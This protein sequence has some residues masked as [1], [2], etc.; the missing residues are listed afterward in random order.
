M[1]RKIALLM[2]GS[3]AVSAVPVMAVSSSASLSG[4]KSNV[5]FGSYLQSDSATSYPSAN[6]SVYVP[7]TG[8]VDA[9]TELDSVFSMKFS[10]NNTNTQVTAGDE[11]II[12]LENG[13]FPVN[14]VDVAGSFDFLTRNTDGDLISL[15]GHNLVINSAGQ[16]DSV[17]NPNETSYTYT[18]EVTPLTEDEITGGLNPNEGDHLSALTEEY[19]VA[20]N[21]ALL[22]FKYTNGEWVFDYRLSYQLITGLYSTRST[23]N[24]LLDALNEL[25]ALNGATVADFAGM[26]YKASSN[27]VA[28]IEFALIDRVATDKGILAEDIGTVKN[29]DGS[30]LV[31][32]VNVLVTKVESNAAENGNTLTPVVDPDTTTVGAEVSLRTV[33]AGVLAGNIAY[34]LTEEVDGDEVNH[35]T[36]LVPSGPRTVLNLDPD[37]RA[38]SYYD[39]ATSEIPGATVTTSDGSAT[40]VS[41]FVGV[42]GLG[43]LYEDEDN[44][45]KVTGAT[46]STY[47]AES[48]ID[49]L[50]YRATVP[51]TIEF[52][53]NE[54]AKVTI[55]TT[56]TDDNASTYAPVLRIPMGGVKASGEGAVVVTVDNLGNTA[57]ASSTVTLSNETSLGGEKT[58][59][60]LVGNPIFFEDRTQ[61][62]PLK[63]AELVPDS[64]QA[65]ATGNEIKLKLSPGFRFYNGTGDEYT[66][67][68]TSSSSVSKIEGFNLDDDNDDTLT[69]T[70]SDTDTANLSN[71]VL[72]NVWIEA[73]NED[74]ELDAYITVSS[75]QKGITTETILVAYRNNLGFSLVS[76]LDVE[77][78]DLPV[79]YSGRHYLADETSNMTYAS[80][81]TI[82]VTFSEK[83]PNT[84]VDTRNLDFNLPD[85]VKFTDL[86][87]VTSYNVMGLDEE[88]F[89]I[90]N[91]GQTLRLNRVDTAGDQYTSETELITSFVM[92]LEVS[93]APDFVGDIEVSVEGGGM[94]TDENNPSLVVA[95]AVQPFE[96]KIESTNVNLGYQDYNVSDIVITEKEAGLFL[97]GGMVYLSINAPYGIDEIGFSNAEYSVDENSGL[98][99]ADKTFKINE[100]G[101]GGSGVIEF[102]IEESSYND[103]PA[104]LTLSNVTVG[105]TR[106]VPYG[107]YN[108]K[109]AGNAVL[110]NYETYNYNYENFTVDS[111]AVV[112][113]AGDG[114]NRDD[115]DNVIYQDTKDGFYT[116]TYVN[117]VTPTATID[118]EVKVT[119]GSTTMYVGGVEYT[120]EVAPKLVNGRTLVPLRFVTL[121]LASEED[122]ANP[123]AASMIGWDK[124]TGTATIFLSDGTFV[125]FTIGSTKVNR[126]GAL[127]DMEDGS[128]AVLIDGRTYIPFRDL[129]NALGVT[130]EWDSATSTATYVPK[131]V[132]EN[133]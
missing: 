72:T 20:A 38:T 110:N 46:Y 40:L 73:E 83:V 121:A 109:L 131:A 61:I 35:G 111:K 129:G 75:V 18:I 33:S 94:G 76:T 17:L 52:L 23:D 7:S 117:L 84:L 13:S 42:S 126:N 81:D 27:P 108:L 51:Y 29:S 87:L 96:I 106:A 10:S 132:N 50:K 55:L 124:D 22:E 41:T 91:N 30:T 43:E 127:V 6:S 90:V 100:G 97:E 95:K 63:L 66:P 54:T 5:V 115:F 92:D 71:L 4:D 130:V 15:S 47:S 11:F 116:D 32:D 67:V 60:S 28:D 89:T 57:I 125:S 101:S 104:T 1:K 14:D 64:F 65:T 99:V 37:S 2:A 112:N 70:I 53:T 36:A 93:V 21:G 26:V 123:D 119:I 107:T 8:S 74:K 62:A 80:N 12:T 25:T 39:Y 69:F 9:F 3:M 128:Q 118:K 120:M 49:A 68:L 77:E 86:D 59:F 24:A 113:I 98:E 114:Y 82:R 105:T 88:D 102:E 31:S 19:I 85:G 56:I 79:I 44:A 78:D 122:L 16:Y 45:D 48:S 133:L 58:A 34:T 103:N